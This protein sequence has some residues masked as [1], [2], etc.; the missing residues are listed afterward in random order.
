MDDEDTLE[1][2]REY[3][4]EHLHEGVICPACDQYAKEYR[5]A[6]NANMAVFLIVAA[7][8]HGTDWFRATD[9]VNA[10][11][12]VSWADYSKLRFWGLLEPEG[13]KSDDGN[14]GGR[15][16]ITPLG[17]AFTYHGAKVPSHARIYNNERQGLEGPW[18][19]IVDALGE[20][21]NYD[22]LMRS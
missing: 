10:N 13:A 8:T 12:G 19:S 1:A 11:P 16:R 17:T 6:L 4:R 21:F 9:L 14:S 22:E 7:R 5:R 2:V 15:W 18:T 3:V 20:K